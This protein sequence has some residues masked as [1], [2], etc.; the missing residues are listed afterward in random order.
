MLRDVLSF[1]IPLL[2]A[3]ILIPLA[4]RRALIRHLLSANATTAARAIV[5]PPGRRL[6]RFWQTRLTTQGVLRSGPNGSV[7]LDQD[8]WAE[9]I[10]T[11]R[12]YALLVIT[13]ALAAFILARFL[14]RMS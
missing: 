12:R 8:A 5:L 10:A 11:R 2:P 4:R 7:W 9:F 3:F 14:S 6:D 13:G 1:L